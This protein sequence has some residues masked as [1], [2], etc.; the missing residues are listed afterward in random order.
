[1]ID[2][3]VSDAGVRGTSGV[4]DESVT[5]RQQGASKGCSACCSEHGTALERAMHYIDCFS[6]SRSTE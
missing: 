5:E 1:M 3:V 4:D 2:R 6:E